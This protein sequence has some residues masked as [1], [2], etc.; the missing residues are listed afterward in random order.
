MR[1]PNLYSSFILS[2]AVFMMANFSPASA[3]LV[4]T[5]KSADGWRLLVDGKPFFIKG[6]CYWPTAIGESA[7][8]NTRRNW[9][10]VDDDHNGRNDYAYQTW[11]DV[12]RNNKHDPSEK[13]VGDFELMREMGVNVIRI[14][15]HMT[16]DPELQKIDAPGSKSSNYPPDFSPKKEQQLLRK[17][18]SKYKIRVAM[19]DLLG[20]YTVGTG[21]TW[22]AGTDYN[23]PQQRAYMLQSVKE[24]VLR[25]KDEPYLLMWILGNEN[26]LQ[27]YTHTNAKVFPEAYAKFVNEAALLIKKYDSRHPVAICNGADLLLDYYAKYTPAIDIF[28]LN[29]YQY[30]SFY[31]L[32]KKVALIYDR[33]VMLTEYGQQS[34]AF[35]HGQ[36]NED[37]QA[38]IHHSCWLD[39]YNHRAGQEPP[40]NAIGG[41]VFEWVDEWWFNGDKWHQNLGPDLQGSW[42]YNGIVSLGD[43][44]GGSL[45]RQLRKVYWT[46][47]ELWNKE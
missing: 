37:L 44:S 23:D 31:E 6:M 7:D 8:D 27:Q 46:Y 33:P 9:M 10:I 41:F 47:K 5:Q 28:G 35:K 25:Y 22:N 45:E 26:N 4:T 42:E 30:Q 16:S 19:G 3:A 11:V 32:W 14:Y 34:P 13:N 36:F 21:A 39:I 20:S 40:G 38:K 1:N 2:L 43:G 24:M 29:M 17:L 12:Q 15:N 18:Y